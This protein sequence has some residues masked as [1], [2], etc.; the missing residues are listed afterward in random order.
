MRK[1]KWLGG[2]LCSICL[3]HSALGFTHQQKAA[4]TTI[5]V[6]DTQTVEIIHRVALHDAEHAV[7]RLFTK[8]ADI[9]HAPQT[10]VEFAQYVATHFVLSFYRD[11]E[12]GTHIIHGP[13]HMEGHEVDGQFFWV[14]QTMRL[15][16]E[17]TSVRV[18]HAVLTELWPSQHNLVNIEGLG[19]VRS[20]T[21]SAESPEA[22]LTF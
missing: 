18:R 19:P 5:T 2:V 6:R 20:L 12:A 15:N 14:Y 3:L 4:V 9:L 11:A 17:P 7:K 22:S 10:Q 21:L 13:L 1:S 8:D 16:G